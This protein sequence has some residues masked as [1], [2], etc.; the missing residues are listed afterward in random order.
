MKGIPNEKKK[1]VGPVIT[2]HSSQLKDNQDNQSIR[3]SIK[4]QTK[5]IMNNLPSHHPRLYDQSTN[6]DSHFNLENNFNHYK[7]QPLWLAKSHDC[8]FNRGASHHIFDLQNLFIHSKYSD[9]K[10]IIIGDNN[11]ILITYIDFIIFNLYINTFTLDDFFI[12]TS[13]QKENYFYF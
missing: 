2:A 12:Y 1:K 5:S 9:N 10:D 6:Y 11:K 8:L 13:H 7:Y 4:T 3:I